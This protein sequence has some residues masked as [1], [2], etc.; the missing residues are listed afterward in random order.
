MKFIFFLLAYTILL[1]NN[2]YNKLY[3]IYQ[4]QFYCTSKFIFKSLFFTFL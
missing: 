3:Y 1:L 4:L 2:K